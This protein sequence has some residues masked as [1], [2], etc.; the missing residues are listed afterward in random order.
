MENKRSK[1]DTSVHF[2]KLCNE[3]VSIYLNIL[4][5][6]CVE[7]GSFPDPFKTAAITP[8]HKKRNKDE[9]CINQPISLLCNFNKNFEELLSV[10]TKNISLRTT[11]F[12]KT[13]SVFGRRSQP[14]N[15][16][17]R[18]MPAIGKK[19]S[20]YMFL[21]TNLHALIPYVVSF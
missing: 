21:L 19:Y 9:I 11:F 17:S 5:S 1:Y 2:L 10:R 12:L 20:P 16:I 4:F 7:N 8:I 3:H 6:L 13:N 14:N 15:S 18:V